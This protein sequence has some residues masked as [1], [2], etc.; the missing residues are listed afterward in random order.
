MLRM[1]I[2][3]HSQPDQ[4]QESTFSDAKERSMKYLRLLITAALA[5]FWTGCAPVGSVSP[6]FEEKDKMMETQLLGQWT[7]KS[8]SM[9]ISFTREDPDAR[10]Y[11]VQLIGAPEES[12]EDAPRQIRWRFKANLFRVGSLLFLDLEQEAIEFTWKDRSISQTNDDLGFYL[13]IHTVYRV[14]LERDVLRLAYLDD[15]AVASF[16]TT[17]KLGDAGFVDSKSLLLLPTH[18]LQTQLLAHAEDAKLLSEDMIF[19]RD[20]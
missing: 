13:P 2:R 4:P 8:D 14:D 6:F 12:G 11:H 10:E 7:C 19:E 1:I 16:M 18:E 17:Q 15:N 9:Q 20:K 5:L 3:R